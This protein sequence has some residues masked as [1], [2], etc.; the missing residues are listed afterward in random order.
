MR[1]Y[2]KVVAFVALFALLSSFGPVLA[3]DNKDA[4]VLPEQDGVYDVPGHK[5]LKMRVFV[6]KAKP[7]PTPAPSL[8]CGLADADSAA[9]VGPTGWR[10]P[11]NFGYYLNTAA[12]PSSVGG[13]N[14]QT[15]AQNSFGAWTNVSTG[16]SAQYLGVTSVN[17]ASR[18]Y[19]NILSW[20]RVS[21][22]ALAI[23]Y[24]WYNQTT[25]ESME[26]DTIMNQ[27]YGWKWSNP[28][29]WSSGD[30]CAFA[31]TYDAQD[32][33]THEIGHWFGL[34]DHYTA[35]YADN[36]MYGYGSPMETKKDTI[37]QGD[38]AGLLSVYGL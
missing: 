28:A 12:V 25:G 1:K 14:W 5:E 33:L 37:T 38:A 24:T 26:S 15:I 3:K 7:A 8:V 16:H 9:V 35:E 31:N 11:L 34:V 2:V 30:V 17:R 4:D 36:T 18:D 6:H 29:T 21:N 23:T 10:L 13:V 32:I 19:R 20:G 27:R 22:S